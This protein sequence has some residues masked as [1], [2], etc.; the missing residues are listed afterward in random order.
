MRFP[1]RSSGGGSTRRS[2]FDGTHGWFFRNRSGQAVTVAPRIEAE[3]EALI[4]P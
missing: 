1:W 3:Y 4:R 2:A